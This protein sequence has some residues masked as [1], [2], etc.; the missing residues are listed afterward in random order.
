MPSKIRRVVTGHDDQGDAV[1]MSDNQYET[2]IQ[3]L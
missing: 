2:L 1:F 3:T